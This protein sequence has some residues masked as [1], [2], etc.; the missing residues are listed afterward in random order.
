M[1]Y[2]D[3]ERQAQ[4][5]ALTILGGF[6][7]DGTVL[8]LGPDPQTFWPALTAAPDWNA[9]DPVDAWSTR[10]IGAWARELGAE[11]RFPFGD[12]P[13]PFVTWMLRTGRCHVSPA[14][15]LVHDTHGLMV[16]A[17]GALLLPGRIALPAPRPSPCDGCAAP[18]LSACPVGAIDPQGYDLDACHAHLSGPNACMAQGCA[19]RRACPVSPPRPAAQSAHHMS[20]FHRELP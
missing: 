13:Q 17:R 18:C 15:L 19:I 10:V 1:T 2:A 4:A 16:S 11:A 14:H 8:I 3:L 6:H 20:F 9:P 7:E 5:R 12:P